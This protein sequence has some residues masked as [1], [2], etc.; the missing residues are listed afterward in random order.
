MNLLRKLRRIL[1][2][3]NYDFTITIKIYFRYIL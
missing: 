1:Y 2:L 3:L